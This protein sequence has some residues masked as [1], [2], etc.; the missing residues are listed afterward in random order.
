MS[1]PDGYL[2]LNRANDQR[3]EQLRARSSAPVLLLKTGSTAGKLQKL[4]DAY[5][6]GEH[7]RTRPGSSDGRSPN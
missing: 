3:L 2:L 4:Q 1:W 7:L 5:V 6:P